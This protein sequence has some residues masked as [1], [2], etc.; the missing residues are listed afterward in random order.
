MY[1]VWL[2][3]PGEGLI[4]EERRQFMWQSATTARALRR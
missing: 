2:P 3:G 4:V 1:L